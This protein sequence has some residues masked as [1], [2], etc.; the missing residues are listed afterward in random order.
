ML[1]ERRFLEFLDVRRIPPTLDALNALNA[2]Q[3]A[4]WFQTRQLGTRGGVVATATF[5]DT[6]KTWSSFLAREEIFDDSPLQRV[7]RMKV[8]VI[9]RQ[10]YTRAEVRAILE[11]CEVSRA[12]ER[13]RLLVLLLLDSGTRIGEAAGLK[14]TDVRLDLRTVRV[15][16]KGNRERT[17]PI[18]VPHQSDGGPLFRAYRAYLKIR[19]RRVARAPDRAGEQLFLTNAGYPLTAAG[20]TDV[21]KRL[22]DAA[23]VADTTAHRF[24]HTYATVY[25]TKYPGDEMGLRRILGHLSHDVLQAYVHLASTAIAQRAGRVAPTGTWLYERDA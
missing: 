10:P 18:G 5:L 22:G 17:I 13:D 23:G 3:A 24:R 1:Y 2:R 6:L 20:G 19:E 12:P 4:L 21:I 9:E 11:A 25:L 8:R 7:K 15:L 16:G 14:V